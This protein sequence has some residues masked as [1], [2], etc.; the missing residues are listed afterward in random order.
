MR[1][2]NKNNFL[3][4]INID[5]LVLLFLFFL[6]SSAKAIGV[7]DEI[8]NLAEQ[9]RQ[10]LNTFMKENLR[11][12]LGCEYGGQLVRDTDKQNLCKLAKKA[13]IRL[14]EITKIQIRLKENIENYHGSD[15]DEKYGSTGLWRTLFANIYETTIN[16][17]RLDFCFAI[18]TE[19]SQK[20][21][22]LHEILKN[23]D[24]LD[25]T[26]V[27]INCRFLQAATT[28]LLSQTELTYKPSAIYQL[29]S[30]LTEQNC[31]EKIY[32]RALIKKIKLIGRTRPVDLDKLADKIAASGCAN[33]F[34]LILSLAY[35]RRQLNTSKAFEKTIN[36]W[37]QTKDF[38][39]SALLS[40]LSAEAISEK[41]S[42][43]DMEKISVFE[44]ELATQAAWKDGAANHKKMLEHLSAIKKFQAP[45]VLY[46][47][48]IRLADSSP[49]KTVDLLIQT[50]QLQQMQ[51]SHTLDIAPETIAEDAARFAANLFGVDLLDYQQVC[52]A[53]ENFYATV[54]KNARLLNYETPP[55]M[56]TEE[57]DTELTYLLDSA[58]IN[59]G[60]SKKSKKLA[61]K[62]AAGQTGR[63]RNI[64]RLELTMQATEGKKHKDQQ[65]LNDLTDQLS[66]LIANCCLQKKMNLKVRAKAINRYCQ[67]L[68]EFADQD[69]YQQVLSILTANET[70]RD[71][72]LNV[73]KSK[74]WARL[75]RLDES[76]KC[77]VEIC[78]IDHFEHAGEAMD[79]L[80]EFIDKIE[81]SQ[82][83]AEDFSTMTEDYEKIAQFCYDCLDGSQR[84]MAGLYLIET[85]LF[86]NDQSELKL[87]A[88]D[89]LLKK[90]AADGKD[91]GSDVNMVRC[92]AR[93]MREK[94]KF[95]QS[96]KLWAKVCLI[97]K[98]ENSKGGRHSW[99]WWRAKFYELDCQLMAVKNE[100]NLSIKPAEIRQT[101]RDI[102]HTI[103]VLESSSSDIPPFWAK[104][105]AETKEQ[106]LSWASNVD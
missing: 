91:G 46:V 69:S 12:R 24:S 64:A 9:S 56:T 75:G 3:S 6:A 23:I 92:Q 93:L 54:E 11:V 15:W 68:L 26:K 81:Q 61:Q 10:T 17:Y 73:P 89:R 13:T 94:G 32:F 76:A 85:G 28:A 29:D 19:P 45:L 57:V 16:K 99:K 65:Q 90:L 52:K 72:N 31:P 67:L 80:V 100:V 14:E 106:C 22:I 1:V 63:W 5:C 53:F 8:N 35:L 66:D 74:A 27:S 78:D 30:I 102:F 37:P 88:A 44:A 51:K 18:A 25:H 58:L 98:K 77:M 7:A 36:T 62:I 101:Q 2:G 86:I 42:E 39:A 104:K 43:Q 34:E 38:L 71:P 82:L 60:R 48:A 55:S 83:Q 40:Y 96:A 95:R 50:S 70:Y 47:T 33:D 4:L 84:Q 49:S 97:R 59:H 79:L 21:K 87:Q 41:L 103:E 105:L 20:N